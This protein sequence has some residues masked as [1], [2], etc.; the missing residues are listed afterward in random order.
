MPVLAICGQQA[1]NAIG[2]HYQQGVDVP[3]MLRDVAGAFVH[4][5]ATPAQVRHLIDRAVRTAIGE[6]RVTA[7]VLPNDLQELPYADPPRAHGTLHSGVG[8]TAPKI[9]PYE[10]DLRRAADIL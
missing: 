2:G 1:R 5:G 6:R 4:Q 9:V 7:L 10:A 8:Y 3:A